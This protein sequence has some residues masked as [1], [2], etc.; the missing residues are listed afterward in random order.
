[1]SLWKPEQANQN[2]SWSRHQINVAGFALTMPRLLI[3]FPKSPPW[4][5]NIFPIK[6]PTSI[7]VLYCCYP[8]LCQIHLSVWSVLYACLW[9]WTNNTQTQIRK[10]LILLIGFSSQPFTVTTLKHRIIS[11]VNLLG[12]IQSLPK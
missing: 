6:Y 3:I 12:V 5:C 4:A 9:D 1:M 8:F 10:G 11:F 2:Q 7:L